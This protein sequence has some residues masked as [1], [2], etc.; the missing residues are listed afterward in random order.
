M[1]ALTPSKLRT[2]I[3]IPARRTPHITEMTLFLKSSFKKLAAS[4][5]VHAPVPGSG[6]P[7]KISN[8][9]NIPF[10]AEA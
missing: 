8:A 3:I 4:V 1:K 2:V 7:T 6:I 9:Q 5:P 10:P